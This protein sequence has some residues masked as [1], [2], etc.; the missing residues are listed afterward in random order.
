MARETAFEKMAQRVR[1][2]ETE[3]DQLKSVIP[4]TRAQLILI[5]KKL[6]EDKPRIPRLEATARIS[7]EVERLNLI[8]LEHGIADCE[9]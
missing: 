2:L 1:Q 5:M 7:R 4:F 6:T 8:M 9:D 3:V